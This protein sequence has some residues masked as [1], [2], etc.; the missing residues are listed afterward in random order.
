MYDSFLSGSLPPDR[1]GW[2][3]VEMARGT[4]GAR[5]AESVLALS[6][7][8]GSGHDVSGWRMWRVVWEWMGGGLGS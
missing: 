6:R 1:G 2:R 3:G 7:K 8:G 5:S 4:R